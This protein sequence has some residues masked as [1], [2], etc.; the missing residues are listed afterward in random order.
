MNKQ[1]LMMMMMMM[2]I[3]QTTAHNTL[4]D[5][6]SPHSSKNNEWLHETSNVNLRSLEYC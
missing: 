3:L 5:P 2:M 6:I 4:G 1:I